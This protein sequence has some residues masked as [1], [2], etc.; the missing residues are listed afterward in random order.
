MSLAQAGAIFRPSSLLLQEEQAIIAEDN[1][2]LFDE[3]GIKRGPDFDSTKRNVILIVMTAVIFIAIVALYDVLRLFISVFYLRHDYS[4]PPEEVKSILPLRQ[5]SLGSAAIF[6]L[7]CVLI[8]L[9]VVP[10]LVNVISS[11][12]A[13]RKG[14]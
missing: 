12:G 11:S 13:N 1:P 14:R 8:A 6:A 2:T 3:L 9:I 7:F 4:I 10:I 5:D